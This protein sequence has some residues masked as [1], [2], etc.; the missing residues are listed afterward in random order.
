MINAPKGTIDIT[1][2]VVYKWRYIE[3]KLR[4]LAA[5]SNFKEIRTPVFENTELFARGVGDTSDIVNKEMYTFD[6]KGGRSMTLR[7][8]GTAGVVR[9]FIENSMYAKTLPAKLY[10]IISCY[11][12]EKPQAGRLREF[13]QFGVEMFG[14]AS[15]SG[16]AEIISLADSIFKEFGVD[17]ISL[18]INNIGCPEC[19][20]KY[21]DKLKEFLEPKKDGLCT[22]CQ[23]RLDKNPMRIFD[24]KSEICAS[25][26][27]DAPRIFDC[28]CD[29]CK[30]HFNEVLSYLDK[31]GIKYNIDK[32]IVR[33]LDYYT[34]TVFEFVSSNIG[35]Q[36][37]V[38]GGGRYDNLV[39][40]IGGK[41]CSGIGFAMGL[42]RFILLLESAGIEIPENE[43]CDFY[44]ASFDKE[45]D[46][47]AAL[48]ASKLKKAGFSC[49]KDLSGRSFGAQMKYSNKINAKY[50]IAIG[51]NEIKSGIFSVKN[52][53]TG[54]SNEMS[55]EKIIEKGWL[56]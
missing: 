49:D 12:Y 28:V 11:R 39:E 40:E 48:I 47:Y 20:K 34:K 23:E 44:I 7:P 25:L 8:E 22:T 4:N 54:E 51:E 35:A 27:K 52:M 33:G 46:M 15:P 6:D 24:C 29:N 37:T 41:K 36:G 32:N 31:T 38:L 30:D 55:L 43:R 19:R 9:S 14:A 45:S 1:P 13:R 18:N 5:L 56:D 3:K 10:Y 50:L 21:N 17:N 42:E 2:D 16:D 26:I 53:D